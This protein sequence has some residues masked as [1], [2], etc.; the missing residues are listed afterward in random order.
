MQ[1]FLG[2]AARRAASLLVWLTLASCGDP[3]EPDLLA[4]PPPSGYDRSAL[5]WPALRRDQA[6][7]DVALAQHLLSLRG[8][9]AP[10]HGRFDAATEHAV[11]QWQAAWG[12]P[13]TGVIGNTTWPRL[14]RWLDD[15][16][17]PELIAAVQALLIEAGAPLTPVG[18]LDAA[19][20][21]ALRALQ[22]TSC[23]SSTG[24]FG[25]WGYSAL[26]SGQRFCPG[27]LLGELSAAQVAALARDAGLP[28]GE[29]L[30]AALAIAAAESRSTTNALGRNGP[31]AG[32]A[33]GSL[34]V[35]LWQLNDCY[36]AEIDR[37]CAVD[38]ACNARAMSAISRGGTDFAPWTT[39]RNGAYATHLE[40]ARVAAAAAC[41]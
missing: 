23:L 13:V 20:E 38:A 39:F 7:A 19:T 27:A 22:T 36:H 21:E 1:E 10:R 17:P 18:V 4:E 12:L 5:S 3:A 9:A 32:C 24:E 16:A 29:S 35:G 41:R 37:R 33:H 31:T 6:G 11:Q 40:A 15:E 14:V 28:C 8:F 26:L 25:S 2:K 30:A 34:D